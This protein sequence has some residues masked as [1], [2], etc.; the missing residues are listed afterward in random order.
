MLASPAVPSPTLAEMTSR[1]HP[2]FW[3]TLL[4]VLPATVA[5]ITLDG[6]APAAALASMAVFRAEVAL[7]VFIAG[8]VIAVLLWMAY[9]GQAARIEIPGGTRIDPAT[10][11]PLRRSE[12]RRDLRS[13]A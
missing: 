7:A 11:R 2:F 9:H 12:S 5:A 3:V 1:P 13:G 4:P 10:A 6:P 8:Y